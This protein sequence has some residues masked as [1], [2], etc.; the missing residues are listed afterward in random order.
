MAWEP[1]SGRRFVWVE[2]GEAN[3]HYLLDS[4]SLFR[5]FG[6]WL[7]FEPVEMSKKELRQR[8]RQVVRVRA[9]LG[10]ALVVLDPK[11]PAAAGGKPLDGRPASV[12]LRELIDHDAFYP[13]A[14][15]A[16]AAGLDR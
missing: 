15:S 5:G 1:R 8:V 9:E 12:E 16:T 3:V 10:A 11:R 4:S 13:P 2:D 14:L 7:D 6:P